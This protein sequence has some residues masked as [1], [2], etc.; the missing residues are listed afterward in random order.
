[1]RV[2]LTASGQLT[3]SLTSPLIPWLARS[4]SAA[5]TVEAA[6]S[7]SIR[8]V[9]RASSAAI[10]AKL[11]PTTADTAGLSPVTVSISTL[12]PAVAMWR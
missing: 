3:F 6:A 10:A 5:A 7:V 8:S 12:A 4:L 1:M 11:I 2:D 9:L